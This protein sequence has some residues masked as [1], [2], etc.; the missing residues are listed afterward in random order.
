MTVCDCAIGPKDAP[1]LQWYQDKTGQ[2]KDQTVAALKRYK[3]NRCP[4]HGDGRRL[5]NR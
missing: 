5:R 4:K 2:S 3:R 1:A